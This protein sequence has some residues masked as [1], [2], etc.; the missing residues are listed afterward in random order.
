MSLRRLDRALDDGLQ[1]LKAEAE[2]RRSRQFRQLA[3]I[4]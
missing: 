3:V 2:R 1:D 4:D